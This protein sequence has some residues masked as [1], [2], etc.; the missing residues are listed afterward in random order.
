METDNEAIGII[1]CAC[2][3]S[4]IVNFDISRTLL[5]VYNLLLWREQINDKHI[6]V[7]REYR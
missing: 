4:G 1:M 7:P 2:A 6:C 3:E 5:Y